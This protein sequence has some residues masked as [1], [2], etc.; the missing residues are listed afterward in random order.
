MSAYVVF[1]HG[2]ASRGGDAYQSAVAKRFRKLV[3][4]QHAAVENPYWGKS[5]ANPEG[6]RYKCL[7]NYDDPTAGGAAP[8][9][10]G[11]RGL[12]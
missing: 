12:S 3:F 8:A 9:R 2:V 4:G 11:T 5:G 10:P 6:G 7:P 1:V